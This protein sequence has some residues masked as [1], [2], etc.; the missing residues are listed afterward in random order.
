MDS[1]YKSCSFSALLVS[2]LVLMDYLFGQGSLVCF[3]LEDGLSFN[4][5][6]DGL[7]FWTFWVKPQIKTSGSFNPCFDGLPFWTAGKLGFIVF[8]RQILRLFGN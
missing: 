8:S 1:A 2:I 5:C 6:F 7:P 3:E 4:P